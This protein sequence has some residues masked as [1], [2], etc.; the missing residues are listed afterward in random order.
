MS[1]EN[2]CATYPTRQRK[3]VARF[4]YDSDGNVEDNYRQRS[5]RKKN[6]LKT[7]SQNIFGQNNRQKGVFLYG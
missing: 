7:F 4:G 3:T 5:T 6:Q 1:D 2:P